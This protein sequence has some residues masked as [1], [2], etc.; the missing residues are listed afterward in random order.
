MLIG[1][2]LRAAREL[3][4]ISARKLDALAGLTP[5][6]TWKVEGSKTGNVG[7][8]TL[9]VL[10]RVLGL[11]LEQLVNDVGE[12]PTAEEVKAAIARAQAPRASDRSREDAATDEGDPPTEDDND[13]PSG[14]KT[15]VDSGG[16]YSQAPLKR[17]RAGSQG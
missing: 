4:G 16:E 7:T 15:V 5:G 3:G 9:T 17:G 6:T 11:N 8:K 1:E 13:P 2:K 14:P 10:A 12:P